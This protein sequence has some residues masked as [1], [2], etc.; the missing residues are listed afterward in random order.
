[1]RAREDHKK[2]LSSICPKPHARIGETLTLRL[3]CIGLVGAAQ[4]YIWRDI[5]KVSVVDY[6]M[7]CYVPVYQRLL[8][9]QSVTRS[10][11]RARYARQ[12]ASLDEQGRAQLEEKWDR[13]M[14]LFPRSVSNLDLVISVS[15]SWFRHVWSD[16]FEKFGL[17]GINTHQTRATGKP[18]VPSSWQMTCPSYRP[19]V[20]Q[21]R[22]PGDVDFAT[23]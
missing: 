16:W 17:S 11:L 22:R 9:R 6:G 7:P 5:S 3:G 13:T 1:M 19:S 20:G 10:K 12:L 18:V 23:T 8:N 14:P 21:L 15:Y 4:P 2:C